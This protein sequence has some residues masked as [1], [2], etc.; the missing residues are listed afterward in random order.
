[1]GERGGAEP[2]TRFVAVDWSGAR[3]LPSQRERI[4]V[5]VVE[6]GELVELSAGRTRDETVDYVAALATAAD[7]A[8]VGLD[9]SF[10]FP[11]WFAREH[12]CDDAAG[13]WQL[14]AERGDEWLRACPA[15]FFGLRGTRRPVGVELFRAE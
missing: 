14:A 1:M 2:E 8:V 7:P 12:G 10:G 3:D 9:F 6:G 13:V 5:A 4:W 11:E 15:P